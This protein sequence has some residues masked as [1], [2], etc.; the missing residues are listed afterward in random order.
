M[1]DPLEDIKA[2][3]RYSDASV[4]LVTLFGFQGA[5]RGVQV[6]VKT[7]KIGPLIIPLEGQ[8]LAEIYSMLGEFAESHPADLEPCPTC[9]DPEDC[10]CIE[11]PA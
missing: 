8:S 7:R 2:A 10:H 1:S 9:G 3:M 11:D 5:N 6:K 4:R